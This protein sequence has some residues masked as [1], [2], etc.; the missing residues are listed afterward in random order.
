VTL[1]KIKSLEAPFACQLLFEATDAIP[2]FLHTIWT[3]DGN[4]QFQDIGFHER[5]EVEFSCEPAIAASCEEAFP[6]PHVGGPVRELLN[7]LIAVL[8]DALGHL[9]EKM[10]RFAVCDQLYSPEPA[11]RAQDLIG[12]PPRIGR[13]CGHSVSSKPVNDGLTTR[14]EV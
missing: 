2:I 12:N 8:S 14:H 10:K 1:R 5:I 7:G 11:K 4:S 13:V 9:I 6:L 3:L